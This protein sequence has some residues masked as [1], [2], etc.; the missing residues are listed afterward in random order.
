MDFDHRT[1][2]SQGGRSIY[3]NMQVLCPSCHANKSRNF[4]G[5]GFETVP[6]VGGEPGCLACWEWQTLGRLH[7]QHFFDRVMSECSSRWS[8]TSTEPVCSGTVQ[9]KL[10]RSRSASPF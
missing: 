10:Y 2:W 5:G 7:L 8:D 6:A 4:D 1:P 3:A 9:F